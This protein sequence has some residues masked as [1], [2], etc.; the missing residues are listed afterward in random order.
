MRLPKAAK[1]E[2]SVAMVHNKIGGGFANGSAGKHRTA[3]ALPQGNGSR[4][5]AW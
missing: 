2:E 5:V 4:R 1:F 3:A